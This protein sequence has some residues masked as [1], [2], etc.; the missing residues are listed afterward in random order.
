MNY[1]LVDDDVTFRGRLARALKSRGLSVFEAEGLSETKEILA[2]LSPDRAVVD[3]KLK[4]EWGLN[5]LKEII[6]SGCKE[7]VVLSGY[8]SIPSA[9]EALKIGAL[10]FLSKP[11]TV[12]ELLDGFEGTLQS[13]KVPTLEEYE[14][15]YILRVLN[16]NDGNITKAAKVLG[17]H[18]QSLQR[19]LRERHF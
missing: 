15:D 1:L 19:K 6:N 9:V 16:D 18:R 10:N 8:G 5:I 4:G 12:D 7:A 14:W 11:I 2:K 17:V 13:S 3:L